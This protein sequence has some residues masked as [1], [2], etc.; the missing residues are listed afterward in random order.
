MQSLPASAGSLVSRVCLFV[1]GILCASIAYAQSSGTGVLS[2]RV[3]NSV[4]NEYVRNAEVRIKDSIQSTVSGNGGNFRIANL[5][6]GPVEV[7][8]SYAGYADVRSTATIRNGQ[9]T[10][11]ELE[12]TS[13]GSSTVGD[14]GTVVMAEFVVSSEIEGNAKALMEQR[15]SMDL[16]RSIASDVFGDVT[17]GNVG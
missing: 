9:T 2:G 8:V 1:F 10:T 6:E 14:D 13:R 5:P 12:F 3:Y 17:E 15:N 4:T 7:V 11:L 16:G